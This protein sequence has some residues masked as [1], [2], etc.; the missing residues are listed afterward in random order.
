MILV[1]YIF[2]ID[3][4]KQSLYISNIIYKINIRYYL[5]IVT[6]VVHTIFKGSL[7]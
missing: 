5:I 1:F 7:R 3:L 2:F 6:L 4:I